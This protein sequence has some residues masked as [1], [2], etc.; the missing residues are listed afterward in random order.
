MTTEHLR[1]TL[2]ASP[3]LPFTIRMADGR[4]FNVPHPDFVWIPPSSRIAFIH[5]PD[6]S[7]SI[8]DLLLMTE[9]ERSQP[10]NARA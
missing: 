8:V 3:F 6:K 7:Y 4:T 10:P 2:R 1:S 5:S 9:L